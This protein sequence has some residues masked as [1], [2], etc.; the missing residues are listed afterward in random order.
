MEGPRVKGTLF[1]RVCDQA[2]AMWGKGCLGQ[3]TENR[4]EEDAWYPACDF[5][6]LLDAVKAGPGRNSPLS[7]YLLGVGAIK[8]DPAWQ[9]TFASMDPADVF[10]STERQETL[11]IIGAQ[12]AVPVGAK[13]VRVEVPGGIGS[14][15]W[16]DFYRGQ[17]Q[18]VLELTGRTGVV[19]LLPGSGDGRRRYDVKWG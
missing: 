4:I 2:D 16:Y 7:V 10:L 9:E 17:L 5:C 14:Q 3:S 15:S 18:G 8:G 1:I 11:Y 6:A 12:A 13:H 19:H